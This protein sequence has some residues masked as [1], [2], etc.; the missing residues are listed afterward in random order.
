M[1]AGSLDTR[2]L[3]VNTPRAFPLLATRGSTSGRQDRGGDRFGAHTEQRRGMSPITAPMVGGMLSSKVL[4]HA[5]TPAFARTT[6]RRPRRGGHSV[7]QRTIYSPFPLESS[8]R[9]AQAGSQEE[10]R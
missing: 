8:P 5:A 3:F 10:A 9:P 4:T 7:L 6:R 2:S 1:R